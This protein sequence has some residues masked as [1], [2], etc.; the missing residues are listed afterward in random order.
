VRRIGFTLIELLVV[1]AIVAIL[2]A[3]LF[4]VLARA[5][6]KARQTACN[7]NLR[8]LAQAMRLYLDDN[9][10][11]Y[12]EAY[13]TGKCEPWVSAP[14]LP[15]LPNGHQP[16]EVA[17]RV[18]MEPYVSAPELWR[19]PSDVGVDGKV[20]QPGVQYQHQTR[21]FYDLL[22]ASYAWGGVDFRLQGPKWLA[23]K[24]EREIKDPAGTGLFWDL[25]DWHYW[26]ERS[27]TYTRRASFHNIVI[28]DGH[29]KP[30]P[31]AVWVATVN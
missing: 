30:L 8:Q 10:G 17:I 5:K 21:P 19:C 26:P 28:C 18:V 1:I 29:E 20:N 24:R 31:K 2:A 12:P 22:G 11:R 6:E 9:D 13:N 23:G 14:D 7:S 3:L 4:P 27:V 25:H 16:H 15:P